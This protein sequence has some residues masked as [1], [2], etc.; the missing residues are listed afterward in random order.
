MSSAEAELGAAV[1]ARSA[2]DNAA[3]E[4]RRRD[5][6]G[7]FDGRRKWSDRIHPTHGFRNGKKTPEHKLFVDPMERRTT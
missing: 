6:Q 7:T 1:K 4:G 5:H 2:R 3:V